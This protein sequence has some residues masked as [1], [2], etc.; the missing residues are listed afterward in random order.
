M[1]EVKSVA[2]LIYTKY[3]EAKGIYAMILWAIRKVFISLFNDPPCSLIIHNKVLNI[4]LSHALPEYINQFQYYDSLPVRIGNYIRKNKGPLCCIDVGANIGDSIAAFYHNG[5]D[6]FLA[7]EPN[8]IFCEY[9]TYNWGSYNNVTI[10][11]AICSNNNTRNNFSTKINSGTA[12][13]FPAAEG[14]SVQVVSVDKLI[15]EFPFASHANVIKI[16]TDG[17]DFDVI[18]GSVN[19]I[20][21]NHPAILFECDIFNNEN[22]TNQ[23]F[24]TLNLLLECGYNHMLLYD[25]FGY[26]MGR[27]SLSDNSSIYKLLFYQLISDFYYFDV[28]VMIDVDLKSF[29]NSEL[30]HFT[31]SP[32]A[33][34]TQNAIIQLNNKFRKSIIDF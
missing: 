33:I 32:K 31:N 20:S 2:T 13:Y 3:L 22:Y 25:N 11:S 8:P 18:K 15:Q 4:P 34:L 28:L 21:D 30:D 7:I 14:I 24:E 9:L 27:Y 23:I 6:K 19:L 17:Y 16:D 26:L 10:V 12:T 5:N 29:H 1:R